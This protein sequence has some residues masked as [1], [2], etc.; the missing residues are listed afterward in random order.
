MMALTI[1]Q[2]YVVRIAFCVTPVHNYILQ[3]FCGSPENTQSVD[4]CEEG[5]TYG[6]YH[7][8]RKSK[9][10]DIFICQHVCNKINVGIEPFII[11]RSS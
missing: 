7:G 3:F 2:I 10:H 11:Q 1:S 9:R 5:K 6:K 8:L 4:K